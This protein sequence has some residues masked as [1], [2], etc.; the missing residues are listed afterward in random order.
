MNDDESYQN[1][2]S[3]LV[4]KLGAVIGLQSSMYVA[5]LDL[6]HAHPEPLS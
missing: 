1:S 2:F 4:K 3:F 6:L 5:K